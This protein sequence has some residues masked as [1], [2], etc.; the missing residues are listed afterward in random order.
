MAIV[1]DGITVIRVVFPLPPPPFKNRLKFYSLFFFFFLKASM[2]K[3]L[4]REF[5]VQVPRELDVLQWPH[6]CL[7]SDGKHTTVRRRRGFLSVSPAA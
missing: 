5:A 3:A 4:S 1:C 2:C 6:H 7:P